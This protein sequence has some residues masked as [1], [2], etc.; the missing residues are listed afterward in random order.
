[1]SISDQRYFCKIALML[2]RRLEADPD[3]FLRALTVEAQ[4]LAKAGQKVNLA[5]ALPASVMGPS[6]QG[7]SGAGLPTF[8][9]ILELSAAP[10]IS[11]QALAKPLGGIGGRIAALLDPARSGVLAGTEHIVMPGEAPVMLFC[12]LRRLDRLTRE[13]FQRYWLDV[14]AE[15][16]RRP[17][18]H[19][20]QFHCEEP[21]TAAAAA[22]TGVAA[23]DFDGVALAYFDDTDRLRAT[24]ADPHIAREA[25][26]D[27]QRFIAHDRSLFLPFASIAIGAA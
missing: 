18:T 20:R 7:A 11:P 10:D 4:T 23:G 3:A 1:M 15:F 27:E 17:G 21:A 6:T 22:A 2:A 19:Y 16:G 5:A 9:A 12:P 13:E 26:A 8:D 24:L 25:Y 14:H